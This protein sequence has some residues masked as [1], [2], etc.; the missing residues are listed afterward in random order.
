M[1][2][3]KCK[4]DLKL[5]HGKLQARKGAWLCMDD[6]ASRI[7]LASIWLLHIIYDS[8]LKQDSYVLM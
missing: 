2:L 7:Y 1:S 6:Q 3:L 4:P 8:S 5:M